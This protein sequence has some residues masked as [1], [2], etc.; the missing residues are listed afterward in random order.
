MN[1][2]NFALVGIFAQSILPAL[3]DWIKRPEG[4]PLAARMA[5]DP[6]APR[7]LKYTGFPGKIYAVYVALLYGRRR[8]GPRSSLGKNQEPR[9]AVPPGAVIEWTNDIP[10]P[11]QLDFRILFR[12]T[13]KWRHRRSADH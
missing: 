6:E 3:W 5:D 10:G 4:N 1:Y 8:A 13:G 7:A 12:H 2:F 11:L 9:S